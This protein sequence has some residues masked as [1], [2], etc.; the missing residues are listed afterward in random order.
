MGIECSL[1]VVGLFDQ[2]PD[3][4]KVSPLVKNTYR[5]RLLWLG[6]NIRNCSEVQQVLDRLGFIKKFAI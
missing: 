5:E 6:R 3:D 2:Q 4:Y 1:L